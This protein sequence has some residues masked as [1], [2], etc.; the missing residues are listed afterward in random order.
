MTRTQFKLLRIA[1]AAIACFAGLFV[2]V[3]VPPTKPG[4]FVT[5]RYAIG[6]TPYS[7]HRGEMHA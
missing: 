2:T 4:S 1:L 6:L 7:P 5:P 3:Y